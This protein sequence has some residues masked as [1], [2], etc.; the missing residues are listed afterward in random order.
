MARSSNKSRFACQSVLKSQAQAQQLQA[1]RKVRDEP[2]AK[3]K[4]RPAKKLKL[5]YKPK[6]ITKN[7][8][9][10]V[11]DE[12]AENSAIFYAPDLIA[13]IVDAISKLH[14]KKPEDK[15]QLTED[16]ATDAGTLFMWM[17]K[18]VYKNVL[19]KDERKEL[20]E[21]MKSRFNLVQRLKCVLTD[22]VFFNSWE[23]EDKKIHKLFVFNNAG[24][25]ADSSDE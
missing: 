17:S 8:A 20:N 14:G 7:V 3:E 9:L 25:F 5:K 21:K 15:I 16:F 22:S 6:Y 19:D 4:V 12:E 2:E 10:I 1:K 11:V 24:L 13:D 18:N 23:P